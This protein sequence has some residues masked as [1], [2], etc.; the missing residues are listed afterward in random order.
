MFFSSY[1]S[2]IEKYL[3]YSIIAIKQRIKMQTPKLTTIQTKK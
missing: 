2:Y 3:K 1:M